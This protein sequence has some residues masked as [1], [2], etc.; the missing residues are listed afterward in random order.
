M[1]N[2][3]SRCDHSG[4]KI[5]LEMLR[6]PAKGLTRAIIFTNEMLALPVHFWQGVTTP[7]F[8]PAHCDPCE[9]GREYRWKAWHGVWNS[10]T[11]QVRILE[12]TA[13]ANKCI[14]DLANKHG[15]TRGIEIQAHRVGGRENG[16]IVIDCRTISLS[17]FDLPDNIDLRPILCN[18]WGIDEHGQFTDKRKRRASWSEKRAAEA[19]EIPRQGDTNRSERDTE[20]EKPVPIGAEPSGNGKNHSTK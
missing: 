6:I 19:V 5:H 7:C 10:K 8:Q 16:R 4:D 1:L 17:G 14:E 18:I 3:Q 12:L 13:R 2:F 15:T 20:P 9:L 11:G